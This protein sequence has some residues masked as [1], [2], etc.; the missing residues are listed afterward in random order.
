MAM[1]DVDEARPWC[2]HCLTPPMGGLLCKILADCRQLGHGS[3]LESCKFVH[4]G[5]EATQQN[6]GDPRQMS[7]TTRSAS[8]HSTSRR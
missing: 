5:H 8:F 7:A 4:N 1:T 3:Q 2:T 6:D